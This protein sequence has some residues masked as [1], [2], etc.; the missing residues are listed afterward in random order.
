[1]LSYKASLDNIVVQGN[2]EKTILDAYVPGFLE[3][4][5]EVPMRI[6]FFRPTLP[7]NNVTF[8]VEPGEGG[9]AHRAGRLAMESVSQSVFPG[10]RASCPRRLIREAL[11]PSFLEWF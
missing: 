7:K 3:S 6:T 10:S 4:R 1:M 2:L 9:V 11:A 8:P 5:F